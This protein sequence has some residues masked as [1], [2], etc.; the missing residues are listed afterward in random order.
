MSPHQLE[1]DITAALTARAAALPSDAAGRVRAVDYHPRAHRNRLPA[2]LGVCAGT[3]GAA[4]AAS[5]ILLGSA[6]AA[7]AGWSPTPSVASTPPEVT[8]TSCQSQ[9]QSMPGDPGSSSSGSATWQEILTDVRGPFTI[10]LYQDGDADAAC[11]TGPSI[12]E[13]DQIG[14][15]GSSGA[16]S[17]RV[18]VR[19]QASGGGSAGGPATSSSGS[20][21]ATAS[22]DLEQV[23]QNHLTTPSDGPYTLVNGRTGSGVT[24]VTLVR[25]DGQDVVASVAD[26]WFVAWWPGSATATS[27]QVTTESGTTTEPLKSVL[28]AGGPDGSPPG[29]SEG[30]SDGG[31]PSGPSLHTG[32]EAGQSTA[33]SG[34]GNTGDS[35][36]AP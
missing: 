9:L 18:S 6:P 11:F 34:S 24:G 19:Q 26:G 36:S 21:S 27:A 25:D 33:N 5:V 23:L 28:P 12:I 16:A 4:A 20:V 13:V 3:A 30:A 29:P 7:Y 22:G 14:S 15:T 31:A 8:A 10:A 35:G 2:T 1:A 32:S 17:N